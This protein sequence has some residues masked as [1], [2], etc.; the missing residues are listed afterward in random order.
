MAVARRKTFG[1]IKKFCQAFLQIQELDTSE[2]AEKLRHHLA[3]GLE[4]TLADI[5]KLLGL[6]YPRDNIRRAYQNI[7][8]GTPTSVAHAVEWLDNALV[9]DMR[10]CLLPIVDDLS[11]TEKTAR[12]RE[13]LKGLADV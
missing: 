7:R 1:L 5:F 11:L 8:T 9:K 4:A 10:D 13:I 2:E 6:Y 3:H 12:F